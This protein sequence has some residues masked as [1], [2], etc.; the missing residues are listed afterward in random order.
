M[1]GS[2]TG[3]Y[4]RKYKSRKD[5]CADWRAGKDFVYHNITSQW[6]GKYCSVRDFTP[7]QKLEL[8]YGLN[9]ERLTF[10]SGGKE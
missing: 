10:V 2:I 3:A 7:D 5:A 1:E 6:D 8:H 4:G 9:H